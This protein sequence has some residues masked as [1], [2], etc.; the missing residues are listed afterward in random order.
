MLSDM[1]NNLMIQ[2][3]GRIEKALDRIER[4][5]DAPTIADKPPV[6]ADAA[7][8]LRSLDSLI[9]QLKEAAHG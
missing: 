9:A 3:I 5:A 7:E 2:A 6:G 8:A 4:A 1:P